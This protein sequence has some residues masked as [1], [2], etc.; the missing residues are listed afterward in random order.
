MAVVSCEMPPNYSKKSLYR[1]ELAQECLPLNKTSKF[2]LGFLVMAVI[3]LVVQS[4]TAWPIVGNCIGVS[5]NTGSGFPT[6][7]PAKNNLAL[8]LSDA[9]PAGVAAKQ[10]FMSSYLDTGREIS[11]YDF[12]GNQLLSFVVYSGSASTQYKSVI[13]KDPLKFIGGSWDNNRV[14]IHNIQITGGNV[15]SESYVG[16]MQ[17]TVG[18]NRF[19]RLLIS[20]EDTVY[21]YVQVTN[22]DELLKGWLTA[23]TKSAT[24]DPAADTPNAI[25]LG[26]KPGDVHLFVGAPQ[27]LSLYNKADFTQVKGFQNNRAST[28][29]KAYLLDNIN[30]LIVFSLAQDTISG[31]S[32][33]VKHD[34]T[35]GSN[36]FIQFIDNTYGGQNANNILNFGPYQYVVTIQTNVANP[37]LTFNSKTDLLLAYQTSLSNPDVRV[38]KDLLPSFQGFVIVN[39]GLLDYFYFG[40]IN[41]VAD[42]NFQSYYLTVDRCVTRDGSNVCTLCLPG[43]GYYRMGTAPNNL[44]QTTAEFPAAWGIDTG[45]SFLASPCTA[46]HCAACVNNYA[47]CTACE[48]DWYLYA[49]YCYHLT[50]NPVIPAGFGIDGN[51]LSPC[52]DNHCLDCKSDYQICLS[53]NQ[54]GAWYK[55]ASDSRCYHPSTS[56]EIA[57]YYGGNPV[58]GL[59]EACQ[60]PECKLCRHDYRVCTWCK[61]W[62]G[63]FLSSPIC[64]HATSSPVFLPGTGPN[65]GSKALQACTQANCQKCDNNYLFCSLCDAGWYLQVGVCYHPVSAPLI[66]DYFGA[67]TVTGL[68]VSCQDTHCKLCKAAYT[69]CNGCDT[70]NG[71]YMDGTTCKH[72]T[73]SPTI[74]DFKGSNTL[75]GL[76]E[77]CLIAHCQLC[78][79]NINSCTYCDVTNGWYWSVT[80]CQH[81][82][83]SPVFPAGRGPNIMT[84]LVVNC[85]DSYCQTCSSSFSTCTTCNAGYYL[86]TG[87]CYHPSTAPLIPDYFGANTVTGLAVSCQDTH[88]KLCKAAYTTCN[89]CDTGNGWYLDGSTCRHATLSPVFGAGTGPNTGN[90]LVEAC[91]DVNCNTCSATKAA[92]QI[93]NSGW[94]MKTGICYHPTLPTIMPDY[95]GANTVTNLAVACQDGHCKLCKADYQTCTGC[96]TGN[97]WYLDGN[98]CR[99][100]TLS[101]IIP[102]FMGPNTVSELVVACQAAHCKLCKVTYVT[103]TGCDTSNGWYFDGA[104]CK[105]ATISPMFNVGTGPDLGT[106]LVELCQEPNCEICSATYQTCTSCTAGWYIKTGLCYH[107]ISSPTI[108]DFFGANTV[109][110][111]AV[112]CQDSHCKLCKATYLTCTGCDTGSG[113]YLDAT[114]CKHATLS[115]SIP[116]FMGANTVSGLVVIC[117]DSHC[118]LCKTSYSTC[119]GCD[120][121]SSWYL[122]GTTCK[123]ATLT[124]VFSPSTGPDTSTGLVVPCQDTNCATCSATYTTCTSCNTGWY[125]KNGACYHPT[126]SPTIPYFFG[127]NTV[128]GDAVSCQET[129]C[130]LCKATYLTC[131]GCDTGTGW[132]LDATTCRHATLSPTIPDTKGPDL[133]LGT[134]VS[135]QETN[136]LLCKSDYVTCTGCDTASGWYLDGTICKHATLGTIFSP[137]TGPN[138]VSGLVVPC[139]D[140]HCN[141]C[142]ANN[143]IC[144]ACQVGAQWFLDGNTCVHATLVPQ[145]PNQK[146]PNVVTGLITTC[147]VSNCK[148]CKTNYNTCTE[149]ISG[150]ER[151][152]NNCV[153]LACLPGEGRSSSNSGQLEPCQTAHCI[154]CCNDS[155]DCLACDVANKFFMDGSNCTFANDIRSEFGGNSDTGEVQACA[156]ENCDDCRQNY[157][158]CKACKGELA[159]MDGKCVKAPKRNIVLAVFATKDSTAQVRFSEAI[160]SKSQISEP[161]EITF[162]D[163]NTNKN[164]SCQTIKCTLLKIDNDGFTLQFDSPEAIVKGDLYINKAAN[165]NVKFDDGLPWTQYPIKVPDVSFLGKQAAAQAVG[166]TLSSMNTARMPISIAVSFAAPAAASFLDILINTIFILKLI[167][168]PI[169]LYPDSILSADLDVNIIPVN[170]D[171]PF[172]N[173]VEGKPECKPPQQFSRYDLSCNLIENEGVSTMQVFAL[174]LLTIFVSWLSNFLI[175]LIMKRLLR[176]GNLKLEEIEKLKNK[177]SLSREEIKKRSKLAKAVSKVGT[178]LGLQFFI[179]KLEGNQVQLSLLSMLA[180]KHASRYSADIMSF[181]LALVYVLFYTGLAVYYFMASLWIWEQIEIKKASKRGLRSNNGSLA[182]AIRLDKSPYSILNYTFEELKV[183][184]HYWQ[185]LMPVTAFL[186]SSAFSLILTGVLGK[187][188]QQATLVLL[189]EALSMGFEL[190]ASV[191]IS[192]AER[193]CEVAMKLFTVLFL[194]FKLIS[195]SEN[196]S[197]ANRQSKLGIPMAL[198]LV[199]LMLVGLVFAV[200]TIG[201][202]IFDGVKAL[203]SKIKAL[204]EIKKIVKEDAK[205]KKFNESNMDQSQNVSIVPKDKD[206]NNRKN[207]I[208]LNIDIPPQKNHGY[209]DKPIKKRKVQFSRGKKQA[210]E[211]DSP[212]QNRD[213]KSGIIK[214]SDSRILV[215]VKASKPSIIKDEIGNVK[216]QAAGQKLKK[217][218]ARSEHIEK[219]EGRFIGHILRKQ[220]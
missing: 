209:L 13:L 6:T 31:D 53:C 158:E 128:T 85:L 68:A 33:F 62:N 76:V 174:L 190:M 65:L 71:W 103:C 210:I 63:W 82:T 77:N 166:S 2:D 165:W 14:R 12:G 95:F 185:L 125:L 114:T 134:I 216:S 1:E 183:P 40:I 133:G 20:D 129:H 8:T 178:V 151:I 157:N 121:G 56:P 126:S 162:V 88:C 46:L 7:L 213:S 146:G 109:T 215:Q 218:Q 47:A 206:V 73:I 144:T 113:W 96:D 187:A 16:E 139:F 118:K 182:Q 35:V 105:H 25:Y 207:E 92:C 156:L 194:V 179:S 122:D 26:I 176:Q 214:N 93:C 119:T 61:H 201:V 34:L 208:S 111:T 86:K 127:A 49:G 3:A 60:D 136:C 9:L 91:V 153:P 107:P 80:D 99:H 43:V 37:K 173:W 197:D 172:Q 55:N 203:I 50:S 100:A 18:G 135:C 193:Y 150:Y 81:A 137:G 188:W 45:A 211:Q 39:N 177:T 59:I 115:P 116:D 145:I 36:P 181:V 75:N 70:G 57:D 23:Y 4:C 124:P 152:S 168:G 67:N 42:N 130:K 220:Q 132:Y 90:G 117:Q 120:T 21:F 106:G 48:A 58:T 138:L 84:G 161:L 163:T 205:N 51:N 195:T 147:S 148:D 184:E 78:K 104:V 19:V 5:T 141:T 198:C 170:I 15:Y 154:S 29:I 160:K 180:L 110:G 66:P 143:L 69:T 72:P 199:G 164:L 98:T 94:Y 87:L 169:L 74:P 54:G 186:R 167:E 171:S 79:P 189:V 97:S 41:M 202:M 24:L 196:I 30:S 191:K 142:S 101:P 102:D 131:T 11:F 155:S 108:P 64:R 175:R 219:Y 83:I 212:L 123:H 28:L 217:S 44:C 89:G 38:Y 192:K 10:V 112:A 140:S 159:L 204:K 52:D 200:W 17:F 149:C 22:F 32:L 27:Y